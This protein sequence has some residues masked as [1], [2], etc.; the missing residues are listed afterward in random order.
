MSVWYRTEKLIPILSISRTPLQ[1]FIT[2]EE[3][4]SLGTSCAFLLS[5]RSNTGTNLVHVPH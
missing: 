5:Q 1:V 4:P 3:K 2:G